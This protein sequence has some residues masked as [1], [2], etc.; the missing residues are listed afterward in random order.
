ML[1]VAFTSGDLDAYANAHEE[2]ATVVVPPDGRVVHGR[3]AIR[4]AAAPVFALRPTL[5]SVVQKKL[6]TDG[7]ALTHA[8]WTLLGTDA[9]G[10][11]TEWSGR[12]TIVS[13]R[14]PDG[15]WGIVLDDPL[16]PS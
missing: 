12:G 7:L 13:R 16:S 8:H 5:T 1:E 15:T 9:D 3:A 6:E 11:R 4:A 10:N 14:R 2:D